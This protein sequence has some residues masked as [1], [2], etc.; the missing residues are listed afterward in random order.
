VRDEAGSLAWCELITSDV[1]AAAK[2]YTGLF[3]WAAQDMPMPGFT[4]T[5][6]AKGETQ[7]GG[8]MQI[9]KEWGPV[10]SHWM[11]YFAVESC[12]ASTD[13]AKRAGAEI[14][15]PPAD[16]P[17]IGRFSM[18]RDPQGAAFALFQATQA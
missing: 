7:V 10:P 15:K 2:F 14:L 16:I 3:G 12:D 18:L 9:Q 11:T 17:N 5:T 4:Y 8:M 1:K 6:F 13:K